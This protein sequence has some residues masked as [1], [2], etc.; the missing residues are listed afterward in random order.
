MTRA[1]SDPT[2]RTFDRWLAAA[3]AGSPDDLARVVEACRGYLLTAAEAALGSTVRPKAG[4]SDLVQ[5]SLV[6]AHQGFD[7]FRGATRDEFLAWVRQILRHNLANAARRYRQ[8]GRRAVAREERLDAGLGVA[9]PGAAPPDRAIAAEDA[10]RL[11]VAV[12]LLPDDAR[13]VLAWRH[14]DRLDWAEIGRR[15]G[16][17]PEAARKVWF[18]AVRQLRQELNPGHDAPPA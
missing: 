4:A 13:A 14:H 17:S 5:D 3:R 7:R 6:E 2:A 11:R 16:R 15:L 9:Q 8:A 1:T 10:G 12:A 18:R